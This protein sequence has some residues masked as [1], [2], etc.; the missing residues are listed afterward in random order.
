MKIQGKPRETIEVEIAA[1]VTATVAHL[2]RKDQS[3]IFSGAYGQ[4]W[5]ASANGGKGGIVP[6]FDTERN[7]RERL[8]RQLVALRGLTPELLLEIAEVPPHVE[9]DV[10]EL[11]ADGC[12]PISHDHIA[13]RETIEIDDPTEKDPGR[14]RS[15]TLAYTLPAYLYS[16]APAEAF[17]RKLDAVQDEFRKL[18]A[19]AEKKS[20]ATSEGSPD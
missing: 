10:P 17:A 3:E 18:K 5:D 1:G 2:T 9:L 4:R 15:K 6:E 7:L 8:R 16:Y 19:E 20:S 11:D 14:K 12:I 13:Y